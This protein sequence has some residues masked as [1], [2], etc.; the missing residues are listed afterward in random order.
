M[1][2]MRLMKACAPYMA[3]AGGGRIVNVCSSAGK[4]PSLTNA[5]YSVTKAA[6]LSLSRTFAD[7][8]A[9]E[10]VLVNAVTPGAV[11]SSLW[12]DEGG[13]ADQVAEQKGIDRE[14]ALSAQADKIPL[15]RFGTEEEIAAVIVVPVLGPGL[16]RDR[17]RVV[18][19]R[20]R[21]AGHPL[22]S[23]TAP[24][25][26]FPRVGRRALLA[27]IF[28][29]RGGSAQVA[30]YVAGALPAAGWEATVATGSLG[31]VGEESNAVTFY[32]GL[33]VRP[34]DYSA[35]AAGGG[36]AS[37]RPSVPALL[38]GPRGRSRP[39]SSPRSATRTTSVWWTPGVSTWPVRARAMPTSCTCTTSRQST[40]P[41]SARSPG[42]REWAICTEPSC[43]CCARS[44]TARPRAG[45]TPRPGPS[46]C[47]AG[48][49]R[50]SGCS[51]SPRTPC[52]ASPT[53]SGWSPSGWCG[54]PTASTPL[55]SSARR[56]RPPGGWSSGGAGWWTSP[57]GG[58]PPAS[59]AA[60]PTARTRWRSSPRDGCCS[61]WAATPRSSASRS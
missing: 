56:P 2:P 51:C 55:A 61:T 19:R 29:P 46:A 33:D 28:F 18:G 43:S 35:S 4:R 53:C 39:V 7:A 47:A 13:L 38:R 24:P 50:A 21:R 11:S 41:P 3:Q 42:S 48:R 59:R 9:G 58:T 10:G 45:I 36:P 52:A 60:C 49:A 20:R 30:R 57:G 12:M 31:P 26:R 6:Q 25:P 27:L 15:G 40:R 34:L 5:A 16:E 1:G 37:G 44:T 32:D 14:E 17:C 23:P 8:W 22:A 54:R